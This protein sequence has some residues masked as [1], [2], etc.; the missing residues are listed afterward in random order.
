LPA[1][2]P[3]GRSLAAAFLWLAPEKRAQHPDAAHSGFVVIRGHGMISPKDS[4]AA[5]YLPQEN[6]SNPFHAP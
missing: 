5:R 1:E 4:Q 2:G 6:G 3:K